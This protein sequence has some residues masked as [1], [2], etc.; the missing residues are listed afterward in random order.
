MVIQIALSSHHEVTNICLDVFSKLHVFHRCVGYVN[1]LLEA[2]GFAVKARNKDGDGSENI[3]IYQSARNQ[4]HTF[5]YSVSLSGRINIISSQSQDRIIKR[6]AVLIESRH[7][8]EVF[9]NAII[10][11]LSRPPRP[12]KICNIIE[13]ACRTMDVENQEEAQLKQS[14]RHFYV[15]SGIHI[16]N[17]PR[18]S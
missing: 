4:Q 14:E 8:V 1:L 18:Q 13:G 12:I 16:S 10:C 7:E 9:L 2:L 11:E 5:E 15:I 17:Y 6:N 3:C